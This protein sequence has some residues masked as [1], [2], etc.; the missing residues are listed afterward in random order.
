MHMVK[1]SQKE[2]Q[3]EENVTMCEWVN[4]M[5]N[6]VEEAWRKQQRKHH[7]EFVQETSHTES[8]TLEATLREGKK[9]LEATE[10]RL[11]KLYNHYNTNTIKSLLR[12]VRQRS[13]TA[14]AT[15]AK[16]D[17]VPSGHG[18]IWCHRDTD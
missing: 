14:L 18:A 2:C 3:E 6:T 16:A 15:S 13:S 4:A 11:E 7:R 9:Q 10:K 12:D 17:G 5:L 8:G 1:S